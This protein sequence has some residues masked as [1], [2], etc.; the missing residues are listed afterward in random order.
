MIR[1]IIHDVGLKSVAISCNVVPRTVYKW[2]KR[3]HLPE[4]EFY[5]K[6]NYAKKIAEVSEGKY[7][8]EHILEVSKK[9]LLSK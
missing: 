7:T 3:G 5:G 6:T 8:A 1:K 2:I 4:T 9:V